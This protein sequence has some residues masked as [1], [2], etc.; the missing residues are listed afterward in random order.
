MKVSELELNSLAKALEADAAGFRMF[1][2][3]LPNFVWLARGDGTVTFFNDPLLNYTGLS[4]RDAL[5]RGFG[6]LIHPQDLEQASEG[7]RESLR[8]GRPYEAEYRLRH[9]AADTYR[10]F[11]TRALPVRAERGEITHWIGTATDVDAQ[12]RASEILDFVIEASGVFAS[13]TSVKDVCGE[14]A[15][16]AVQRFADWCFVVLSD[17]AARFKVA[18]LSHRDPRRVRYIE[19][20][21]HKYPVGEDDS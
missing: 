21:L 8:L 12:R 17:P 7:W 4:E 13:A 15:R 11:L 18:A 14:F 6:A 16:L 10:W 9:A 1:A 19:Q 3:A 5:E 2:N 20:F